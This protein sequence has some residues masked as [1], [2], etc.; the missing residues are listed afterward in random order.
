MPCLPV[1]FERVWRYVL[2][3]ADTQN[4][5]PLSTGRNYRKERAPI[6]ISHS[7]LDSFRPR[8]RVVKPCLPCVES[9][10]SRSEVKCSKLAKLEASY[11]TGAR[12]GGRSEATLQRL[13][14]PAGGMPPSSISCTCLQ[15]PLKLLIWLG[16][17]SLPCLLVLA[18]LCWD[19]I[20]I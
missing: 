8:R 2:Q 10:R 15:S 17:P 1:S 20:Y 13:R 19:Q 7:C 3:V 14:N 5:I 18:C 6:R 4:S 11:L 16:Q 12:A 9:S